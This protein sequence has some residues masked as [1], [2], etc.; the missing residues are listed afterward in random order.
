M[1]PF[2]PFEKRK[3]RAPV[4]VNVGAAYPNQVLTVVLRD[5]A[6]SLA[7]SLD[8]KNIAVTGNIELYKGKPEIVV[9]DAGKITHD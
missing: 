5:D 2:Q 8:G 4:L 6:K 3:S 1:P 7:G 9:K